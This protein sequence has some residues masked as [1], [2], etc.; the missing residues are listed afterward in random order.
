MKCGHAVLPNPWDAGTTRMFENLGFRALATTSTGLAFS[1]GRRDG[2]GAV[3][4]DETF[5]HIAT[6]LAATRLPFSA[7]LENGFGDSP[8]ARSEVGRRITNTTNYVRAALGSNGVVAF[9]NGAGISTVPAAGG[10]ATT[11]VDS[12]IALGG[13]TIDNVAWTRPAAALPPSE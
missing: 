10:A 11:V 7:D 4:S 8:S 6:L 2:D 9:R 1:I 5:Q 12:R 13:G 3:S